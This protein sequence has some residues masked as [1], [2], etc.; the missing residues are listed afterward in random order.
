MEEY[1]RDFIDSLTAYAHW[2]DGLQE[3]GTTGTTLKKAIEKV[4]KSWNYNP[5]KEGG[6]END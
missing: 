1:K 2:K 3:V 4:E 6:K 5:E